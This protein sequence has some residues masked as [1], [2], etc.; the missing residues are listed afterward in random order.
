V[1]NPATEPF[2]ASMCASSNFGSDPCSGLGSS[3]TVPATTPD[4]RAVTRAVIEHAS[5][6][7]TQSQINFLD[8]ELFRVSGV[9]PPLY[10]PSPFDST[11]NSVFSQPVKMYLDPGEEVL[12]GAGSGSRFFCRVGVVGYLVAK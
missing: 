6:N 8:L 2:D 9:H 12:L 5:G 1:D 7:C 3:F 11:G 10:I 4:G